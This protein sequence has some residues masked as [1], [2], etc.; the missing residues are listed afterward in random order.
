M[1]LTVYQTNQRQSAQSSPHHGAVVDIYVTV[2]GQV[3]RITVS[4]YQLMQ[5]T[6]THTHTHT[7]RQTQTDTCAPLLTVPPT[8]SA[9]SSMFSSNS[10]CPRENDMIDTTR[11][12]RFSDGFSAPLAFA[13]TNPFGTVSHPCSPHHFHSLPFSRTRPRDRECVPNVSL[14]P[15]QVQFHSTHTRCVTSILAS[16]PH[17]VG[18]SASTVVATARHTLT[19][20]VELI[21]TA[22]VTCARVRHDAQDLVEGH[23]CIQVHVGEGFTRYCVHVHIVI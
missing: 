6:H 14:K 15:W 21:L 22:C 2:F 12:S 9:L 1:F 11:A 10:D 19:K 3:R 5:H 17:L 20:W 13:T 4:T 16:L 7:Q 8:Y 23:M 18:P